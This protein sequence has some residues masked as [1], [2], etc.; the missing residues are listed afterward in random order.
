MSSCGM[1][2]GG[3][4]WLVANKLTLWCSEL[5]IK[6]SNLTVEDEMSIYGVRHSNHMSIGFETFILDF[7]HI[8]ETMNGG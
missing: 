5:F 3:Y 6:R 8:C 7:Y 2:G 1:C 4:G